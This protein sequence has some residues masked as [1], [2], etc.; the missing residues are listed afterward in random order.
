MLQGKIKL[1]SEFGR[2]SQKELVK[3]EASGELESMQSEFHAGIALGTAGL[4]RAVVAAKR[5]HDGKLYLKVC[6]SFE[7]YCTHHLNQSKSTIYRRLRELAIADVTGKRPTETHM[8]TVVEALTEPNP[9]SK[10]VEVTVVPPKP[11]PKVR[12]D[13][14]DKAYSVNSF[15]TALDLLMVKVKRAAKEDLDF[16]AAIVKVTENYGY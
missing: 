4:L 1:T 14:V 2:S 8:H 3:V 12:M 11:A 5:I 15:D 9:V 7:Y 13:R 6:D 10:Q 16:R